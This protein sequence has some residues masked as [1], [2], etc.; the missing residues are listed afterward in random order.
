MPDLDD[1]D[2]FDQGI[3]AMNQ[4]PAAEIRRRGDRLRRRNTGLAIGAGVLAAAL[5]IGAPVIALDGEGRGR[6][7]E[8]ASPA[9]SQSEAPPGPPVT[10]IP[11]GFALGDAMGTE[12]D[13]AHVGT[14]LGEVVFSSIVICEQ[15]AWSPERPY[16]TTDAL[17]AVWSDGTSGGEQRTL[18]TYADQQ[19]AER[20]LEAI[21]SR[22]SECPAQEASG[23]EQVIEPRLLDSSSGE[24]SL[25]Y[26]DRYLAADGYTGEGNV[27][28]LTRVGNALLID[29]TY[30]GGAGDLAVGQQTVDLLT[31]RAAN[32][33]SGMCVFA[34]EPCGPSDT[35]AEPSVP[36]ASSEAGAAEIPEDFPL[37]VGF[38]A[39]ADES[40]TEPDRSIDSLTLGDLCGSQAWPG[41][42][43][44]QL[45][46][47]LVGIEH[48]ETREL[49]TYSTADQAVAALERVRQTV[50]DECPAAGERE[51]KVFTE[52]SADTGY[53]GYT[54][55]QTYVDGLGGSVHQFVRVGRAVLATESGGELSEASLEPT[56]DQLTADNS[57]VTA[58]MCVW[59]DAGC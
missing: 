55:G 14:E 10:T 41:D 20:A 57:A 29:K 23:D 53:D 52:L 3:P 54:L 2:R 18:A 31:E 39:G 30:I 11:D 44:D 13:P 35:P 6:A 26:V 47:R 21:G 12:Q 17:G 46:V 36:S 15:D 51:G 45:A 38:V 19:D 7:V 9:P 43:T 8:P 33:V 56:S 59:T 24:Q 37:A 1:L 48:Y 32:V 42:A 49:V 22:V 25:A 40:V 27:F 4:L 58:L 16:A 50:R 34:A 28:V 5:A